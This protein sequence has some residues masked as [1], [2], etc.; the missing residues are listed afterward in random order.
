MI[1]STIFGIIG[2]AAFVFFCVKFFNVK[3][4]D[5]KSAF[6]ALIISVVSAALAILCGVAFN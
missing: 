4:N 5:E 2:V 1:L 3:N 6:I